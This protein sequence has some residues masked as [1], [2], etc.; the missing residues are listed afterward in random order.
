MLLRYVRNTGRIVQ[1]VND[2][3]PKGFAERLTDDDH[4]CLVVKG[5]VDLAGQYVEGGELREIPKPIRN[6]RLLTDARHFANCDLRDKAQQRANV[7]HLYRLKCIEAER[8]QAGEGSDL[9]EREARAKGIEPGDLANRI[10]DRARDQTDKAVLAFE[11]A[12]Q[13]AKSEIEKAKTVDQITEII[14]AI[15]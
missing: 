11:I 1:T 5:P 6:K 10:L 12:R 15:S 8:F 13:E 3:V 9:I 2:P 14:S 7:S 4:A